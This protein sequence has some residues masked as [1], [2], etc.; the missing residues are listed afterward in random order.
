MIHS[1]EFRSKTVLITGGTS[2]IGLEAVR[3][4]SSR[5]ANVVFTGRREAEGLAIM[6]E[7]RARD[8]NVFFVQADVTI[9]N[10]H[11]NV[12]NFIETMFGNLDIAFNNAGVELESSIT[13]LSFADYRKIFDINVW[14]VIAAMKFEIELMSQQQRGVIVNTSSIAG[15]VGVPGFSAYSASKHAIEGLTKTTALEYATQGIRINCIAPA[16]ILT[17]M[18]ERYI[19]QDDTKMRQLASLHPNGRLGLPEEVVS[20]VLFLCSSSA[21]FITGESLRVDGGWTAR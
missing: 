5:G 17:P 6:N 8:E 20:A 13:A 10:D 18:V 14:G 9:E 11:L 15:H 16:F 12:F 19:G 2:G 4:F 21:S 3:A 1:D 7:L